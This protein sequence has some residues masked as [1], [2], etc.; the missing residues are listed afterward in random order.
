MAE[1][2]ILVCDACGRP[3]VETVTIKASRGNFV[4]D[5]CATH[6]SELVA[7]ARKPRPG[8]RK[9]VV[10][11]S[12]ASGVKKSSARKPT[13]KRRGRPPKKTP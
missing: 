1:K 7:G 4:K 8:R 12:G 6:V 3:A 10:A 9:G 5:L 11:A 13:G 2:T